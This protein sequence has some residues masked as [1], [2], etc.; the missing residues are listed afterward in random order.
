MDMRKYGQTYLQPADLLKT[1]GKRSGTIEEVRPPETGA[2]FPKPILV[3]ADGKLVT[4]NKISVGN[5]MQEFGFD[6]AD[7][8]GRS[9][10][11][12]RQSG[13]IDGKETEW[14]AVEAVEETEP[15]PKLKLKPQEAP[16]KSTSDGIPF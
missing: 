15:K 8:A 16:K 11:L 4:L 12:T 1:G 3:L 13:L 10:Q 9:V 5:L 2:K 7:W 14:I 6:S